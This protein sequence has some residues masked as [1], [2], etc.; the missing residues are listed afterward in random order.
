MDYIGIIGHKG[1]GRKTFAG[2][3]KDTI[4]YEDNFENYEIDFSEFVNHNINF[5][6]KS[7][8][9]TIIDSFGRY[10]LDVIK[11][12]YSDL[13]PL[14]LEDSKTL[15]SYQVKLDDMTLHQ[16]KQEECV[17]RQYALDQSASKKNIYLELSDFIMYWADNMMKGYF[18]PN[19]W[20]NM[21][22]ADERSNRYGSSRYKIY[23]DVKT[24][25]EYNFIKDRGGCIIVLQCD[26]RKRPGGYNKLGKTTP[27]FTIQIHEGYKG[28]EKDIYNLAQNIKNYFNDGKKDPI[29]D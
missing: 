3:L 29:K 24:K 11:F 4:E 18:G 8:M 6:V 14:D 22:A 13:L 21:M 7:S 2:I 16:D 28:D 15:H 17:T 27:D 25:A 5:P 9:L 20:T 23:Y 10:I 26:S 19:V 1:S 12:T